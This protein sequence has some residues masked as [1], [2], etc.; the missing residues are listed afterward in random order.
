MSCLLVQHEFCWNC[1]AQWTG[2]NHQCQGYS[3]L[4]QMGAKEWNTD[5]D[6]PTEEMQAAVKAAPAVDTALYEYC[7]TRYGT[8]STAQDQIVSRARQLALRT[9]ASDS[10]AALPTSPQVCATG[11]CDMLCCRYKLQPGLKGSLPRGISPSYPLYLRLCP[12]RCNQP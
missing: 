8:Q 4:R 3:D 10:G 11:G 6:G 9:L 12:Y 7:F 5:E 2:Y 1:K